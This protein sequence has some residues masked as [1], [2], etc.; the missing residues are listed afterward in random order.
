MAKRARLPRPWPVTTWL[1]S[2]VE[3]AL[4]A[5]PRLAAALSASGNVIGRTGCAGCAGCG[6]LRRTHATPRAPRAQGAARFSSSCCPWAPPSRARRSA[7]AQVA[8]ARAR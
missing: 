2:L 6:R 7:A 5:Y 4:P 3:R 8:R 1:R